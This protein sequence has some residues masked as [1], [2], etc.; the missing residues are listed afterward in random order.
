MVSRSRKKLT[1]ALIAG[2]LAMIAI[3]IA[4]RLYLPV[5]LQ[6][7]LLPALVSKT[8]LTLERI[9]IQ[10]IGWT[11]ADLGPIRI[12]KA[13]SPVLELDAIQIRY[14]LKALLQR[15]VD[16]IILIGPRLQVTIEDEGVIVAGWSIPARPTHST[17][18]SPGP[19]R[20]ETILPLEIKSIA[21]RDG[22]ITF[23]WR[24]H[25]IEGALNIELDMADLR[26]GNVRAALSLSSR[27]NKL[28]ATAALDSRNDMAIVEVTGGN[29][30]PESFP[31]L[32]NEIGPLSLKGIIQL[33]GR[34]EFQITSLQMRALTARVEFSRLGINGY[35]VTMENALNP[36]G[37]EQPLVVSLKADN[38][39]HWKMTSSPFRL[40]HPVQALLPEI[41][42]TAAWI[43]DAWELSAASGPVD[44]RLPNA[45]LVMPSIGLT[46]RAVAGDQS[47]LQVN[48]H[49]PKPVLTHD[50]V[51]AKAD[52][53]ALAIDV[54]GSRGKALEAL[55]KVEITGAQVDLPDQELRLHQM[56]MHL[57]LQWPLPSKGAEGHIKAGIQWKNKSIGSLSGKLRS[58]ANGLSANLTHL[59]QLFPAMN[60]LIQADVRPN[61][62]RMDLKLPVYKPDKA[63]ELGSLFPAAAGV[64]FNGQ[65]QA[66]AALALNGSVLTGKGSLKLDQGRVNQQETDLKLDGI[67][68]SL[69]FD[70]LP[71]LQ[72][73]PRQTL[74]VAA[75]QLGNIAAE[76]MKAYFQIEADGSIF[77]ENVSMKWCE[78]NISSKSIRLQPK[79]PDLNLTLICDR[80]NLAKVLNQL[81]VAEGEGEGDIS[82]RIPIRWSKNQ[83]YFDNGELTSAPGQTGTIQLRN[84]QTFLQGL[85][86]GTPQ[87]TQLD[88]ATEALKDYTYDWAKLQLNSRKEFLLVALQL[89]GR[90]NRLLPFAYD[91]AKGTFIRFEGNAQAEFKG[92]RL[93]LNFQSPINQLLRYKELLKPNEPHAR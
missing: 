15:K 93:D 32:L 72:S 71:S 50:K 63:I 2:V 20:L 53:I 74:R 35:G 37:H 78:G 58:S 85:A 62:V 6:K 80:I 82:G 18:T 70:N 59:S 67:F 31:D 41:A 66:Q 39:R 45:E 76:E 91:T 19:M 14:G 51:S 69:A 56:S 1:I 28:E 81:G 64:N 57:P 79:N 23:N 34:C 29:L 92:I 11:A 68:I 12:A 38:P 9:E 27:G 40:S 87:H 13:Q 44:V 54:E 16:S 90:P 83:I 24:R 47:R 25:K 52:Q 4:A 3:V 65:L 8:G 5:Y 60:V 43:T 30:N 73:A 10:R 21:L 86:P 55:G 36:Q 22:I 75:L 89:D 17:A 77:I 88:I 49:L 33:A 7:E 26:N 61:S 42:L 46:G 48:F 84:T